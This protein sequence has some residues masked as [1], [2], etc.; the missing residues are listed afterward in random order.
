MSEDADMMVRLWKD[1]RHAE[2]AVQNHGNIILDDDFVNCI[3][4]KNRM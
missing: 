4:S 1:G 3:E 2:I